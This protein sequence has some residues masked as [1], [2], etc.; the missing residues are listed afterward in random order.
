M[1][2]VKERYV[3][4]DIVRVCAILFVIAGHF[5]T[6]NTEFPRTVFWGASMFMQEMSLV[7][8]YIGVPLFI[9]LTG[10]LN[11]KKSNSYKYYKGGIR[12]LVSYLFFSVVTIAFRKY[13]LHEEASWL[14]W[15][16]Q[17]GAF[18]AIPYG[19]YI[20]M[21]IGL[22]LLTPFLNLLYHN[23]PSRKQK[24]WLII[25]LYILT[26][27]PVTLNRHNLGIYVLPEFWTGCFPLVFFFMGAYIKEYQPTVKTWKAL[28]LIISIC[29][30][31]PAAN[32]LLYGGTRLKVDITGGV[33]GMFTP[34]LTVLFFLLVYN[35]RTK[36]T[37]LRTVFAKIS[38]LSLD[39][40]L[41]CY[42]FDR[43]IYPYFLDRYFEGQGQFGKYIFIIVPLVF[44]GSFLAAWAKDIL[45][46]GIGKMWYFA[47]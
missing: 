14:E 23:I 43:L 47:R 9:V 46:K 2:K 11:S 44:A 10:Y 19:W 17:I 15:I 30:I 40:Y 39:M 36:A 29:L 12:V 42:I 13:Y 31:N 27:L 26:A 34:I 41:C 16:F 18:K 21:W 3:G 20:G 1:D 25:A 35:I 8:F 7:F 4:L 22:F 38:V 45:F 5:M 37:G 6:V 28:V 33:F 32:A 24:L